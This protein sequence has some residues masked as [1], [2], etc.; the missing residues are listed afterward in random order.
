MWGPL[1]R[2][3]ATAKRRLNAPGR[4]SGVEVRE[5]SARRCLGWASSPRLGLGLHREG[6]GAGE[7][8]GRSLEGD[9]LQEDL[10]TGHR[11]PQCDPLDRRSPRF[12]SCL[13]GSAGRQRR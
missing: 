1:R 2:T 7:E 10:C 4:Q 8:P 3:D 5:K 9:L 12:I 6:R 13:N 11:S